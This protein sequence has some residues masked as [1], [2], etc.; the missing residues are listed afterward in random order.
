[1]AGN[2]LTYANLLKEMAAQP[3]TQAQRDAANKALRLGNSLSLLNGYYGLTANQQDAFK[4][5]YWEKAVAHNFDSGYLDTI[6]RN[7]LFI[8]RFGMA[9]FKKLESPGERD[10]LLK[11]N[12]VGTE[13]DKRFINEDAQ[14]KVNNNLGMGDQFRYYRSR[15][16]DDAKMELLKSN[17]LSPAE[18]RKDKEE[19]QKAAKAATVVPRGFS[20]GSAS[21]T[22]GQKA[23]NIGIALTEGI[24]SLFG[25]DYYI[26]P[27]G[28]KGEKMNQ[29]ILDDIYSKDIK[30]ATS[31]LDPVVA[32]EYTSLKLNDKQTEAEFKKEC[33][34]RSYKDKDGNPNLG[35]PSFAKYFQGE[36]SFADMEAMTTDEKRKF[37]ARKRAYEKYLP[38]DMVSKT[39]DD[40]ARDWLAENQPWLRRQWLR[41][42]D[43]GISAMAYGAQIVDGTVAEPV[44]EGLDV[45]GAKPK[46]WMDG[47]N[48][49]IDTTKHPILQNPISRVHFYLDD[50]GHSHQ[51]HQMEIDN[52]ALHQLGKEAN[53]SD[54]K[55]ALGTA[56]LTT[57]PMYW[58]RA[59]QFKTLDEDEQKQY[60]KLGVSPYDV[61]YAHNDSAGILWESAKMMSFGLVD[62]VLNLIPWG[63]ELLDLNL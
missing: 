55:G 41:T 10:A 23:F 54:I 38:A 1:M 39:L 52:T 4:T 59:E 27:S 26:N 33:L 6:F 62:G 51:V 17:Y 49:I 5:K 45:L 21:L 63:W 3:P 12:I 48:N 20:G 36:E 37:I 25:S 46:V 18:I 14:G 53:G 15:L 16:S 13:F 34:P 29:K 47:E 44:R 2:S 43:V 31:Q 32:Q 24:S 8:D 35:I 11:H 61:A 60:E 9:R 30:R 57:N 42:K 19:Q 28:F 50:K 22:M 40:D 58:N 7:H 56:W